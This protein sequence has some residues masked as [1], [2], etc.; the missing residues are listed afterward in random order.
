MVYIHAMIVFILSKKT[1]HEAVLLLTIVRVVPY[2]L[3]HTC[4]IKLFANNPEGMKLIP[5]YDFISGT[6]SYAFQFSKLPA[7]WKHT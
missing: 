5:F 6:P 1:S 2:D 3:F 4:G 7:Y